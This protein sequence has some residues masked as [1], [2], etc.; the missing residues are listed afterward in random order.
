ME[1][2]YIKHLSSLLVL[3]IS[4]CMLSCTADND[5]MDW[6]EEKV[7]EILPEIVPAHI[8]GEPNEVDG[9]RVKI[10]GED[11]WHVYPTHFI[12]GFEFEPG[13]S[14]ILKV[15]ITHLANPPQDWYDVEYKL[16]ELISKTLRN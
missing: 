2:F 13:Y 3:L 12:E 6:T 8:F 14:Y 16:V 1:K 15:R 11:Q 10:K 9:M 7:I 4:H 5:D